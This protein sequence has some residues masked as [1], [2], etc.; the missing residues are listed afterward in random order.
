MQSHWLREF[1]LTTQA[2]E[3]SQIWGWCRYKANN[4]NFNLPPNPVQWQTVF[5]NLKNP[6]FRPFWAHFGTKW[7][8]S[9]NWTLSVFRFHNYPQSCKNRKN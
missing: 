9:K 5:K 8:F 2:L 4:M 1:W 7:I 6:E 3:C